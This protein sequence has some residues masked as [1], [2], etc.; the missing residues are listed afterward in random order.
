MANIVSKK[1]IHGKGY[2][3]VNLTKKHFCREN[4]IIFQFKVLLV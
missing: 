1:Q 2:D 3:R 4:V